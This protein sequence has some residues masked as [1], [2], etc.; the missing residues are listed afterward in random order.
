MEQLKVGDKVYKE[1]KGIWS[2][3]TNFYFA[4]VERLTN[5]QAILSNGV[6]LI[7]EPKQSWGRKF[8]EFSEYGDRYER[9]SL[10]T[11]EILAKAKIENIKIK[12]N[13]WFGS[14][15]FTIEQMVTIYDKFYT[16]FSTSE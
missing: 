15:K 14:H 3:F 1:Q 11:D 2:E 13:N 6:R 16:E 9:W 8:I 10:Q 12:A 4:K 5:K 7:N